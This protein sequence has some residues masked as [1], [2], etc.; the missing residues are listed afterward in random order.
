M[1]SDTRSLLAGALRE[2]ASL[3]EVLVVAVLL[4]FAINLLAGAL[5]NL[6]AW[7]ASFIVSL[8]FFVA[9]A[10]I[11][12]LFRR[13]Y[14]RLPRRVVKG[15]FVFDAKNNRVIEVPRYEFVEELCRYLQ[16]AFAE[17]PALKSLWDEQP[18]RRLENRSDPSRFLQERKTYAAA[19]IREALEYFLIDHFSLHIGSYFQKGGLKEE[20]LQVFQRRD[21]PQVLLSNRFMELFTRSLEERTPFHGMRAWRGEEPGRGEEL[22]TVVRALG[23]GG[24]LYHRFNLVLPSGSAVVRLP[25]DAIRI[26]TKRLSLELRTEFGGSWENLPREFERKYLGLERP[27]GPGEYNAYGVSIEVRV[28]F[29]LLALFTRSAWDYYHWVDSF[30]DS[31]ENDFC[32]ESFF[33]RINW[34]LALTVSNVLAHDAAV[35]RAEASKGLTTP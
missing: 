25:D 12:F 28:S 2:R 30:L 31:L 3:V 10:A 5:P 14:S 35:V 1:R 34:E 18:L 29:R 21:I 22:G 19:L 8:S 11:A 33:A 32:K 7:P 27:G 17:N 24:A 9:I 20:R 6:L 4:A 23:E 15:F 16:G 26:A 13:L